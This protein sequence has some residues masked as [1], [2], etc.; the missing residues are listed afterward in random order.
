[1]IGLFSNNS[2]ASTFF[3]PFWDAKAQ[4]LLTS[5]YSTFSA[6]I[7][8]KMSVIEEN[9]K[10]RFPVMISIGTEDTSSPGNQIYLI[11]KVELGPSPTFHLYDPSTD[12]EITMVKSSIGNSYVRVLDTQKYLNSIFGTHTVTCDI[13]GNNARLKVPTGYS[14]TVV[15][16]TGGL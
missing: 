7:S 16:Y 11:T 4:A 14:G 2:Q 15:R 9:I 10:K 5:A 13:D 1:M 12:S 8:D 6:G 3:L